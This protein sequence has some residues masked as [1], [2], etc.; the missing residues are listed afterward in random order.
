MLGV[1]AGKV[2]SGA[3]KGRDLRTWRAILS[4]ERENWVYGKRPPGKESEPQEGPSFGLEV[5]FG[6]ASAPTGKRPL[7]AGSLRPAAHA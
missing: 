2:A 1:G 3:R 6:V 5:P 4:G 7:G